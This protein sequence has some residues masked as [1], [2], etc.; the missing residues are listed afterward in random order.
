MIR[1][2]NISVE[3]D[4]K[5]VLQNFNLTIRRGEKVVIRGNSGRGKTTLL[6]LLLGFVQAQEGRVFIDGIQITPETIWTARRHLALVGQSVDLGKG[7]VQELLEQIL[8]YETN[9]KRNS[10][11]EQLTALFEKFDLDSDKLHK[12]FSDLSGGEKQRIGIILAILLKRDIF[13]LDEVTSALDKTLKQKV[14]RFFLEYRPETVIAISHDKDWD[15][16]KGVRV[17]DLGER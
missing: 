4:G 12:E 2:E 17:V 14:I 1:Y 3:F 8:S 9:R 11:Q 10:N 15:T 7:S 6:N 16:A 5:S 13:L